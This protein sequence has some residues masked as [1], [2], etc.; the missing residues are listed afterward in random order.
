MSTPGDE[1]AERPTKPSPFAGLPSYSDHLA[2]Y[3]FDAES[4][5]AYQCGDCEVPSPQVRG[6]PL[7]SL[8]LLPFVLFWR[9]DRPMKCLGCMRRHILI[10][11]PLAILLSHLFS[12]VVVVWWLVVFVKT[13]FRHPS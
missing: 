7:L 8:G 5:V 1:Q 10:R 4:P 9:I 12:P 11:L 3:G 6:Y 2:S 13:F